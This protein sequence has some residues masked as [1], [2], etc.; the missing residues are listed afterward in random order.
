MSEYLD[1]LKETNLLTES[2]VSNKKVE[3]KDPSLADILG[4]GLALTEDEQKELSEDLGMI[5]A[6]VVAGL[7]GLAAAAAIIKSAISYVKLSSSHPEC[8]KYKVAYRMKCNR[9]VNLRKRVFILRSK[10][11]LCNASD[12]A[13]ACKERVKREIDVIAGKIRAVGSIEGVEGTKG[14]GISKEAKPAPLQNPKEREIKISFKHKK[15]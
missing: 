1:S 5:A 12:N 15:Q 13:P 9:I 4:K 10:M 14:T 11:A 7:A 2:F 3:I 8:K 6:S